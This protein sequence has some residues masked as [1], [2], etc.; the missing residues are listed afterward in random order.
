MRP[1]SVGDYK[2][3]IAALAFS[4]GGDQAASG[5]WD[6]SARAWDAK[7]G[8]LLRQFVGNQAVVRGVAFA[9]GGRQLV[10]TSWDGTARLWDAATGSERFKYQGRPLRGSRDAGDTGGAEGQG[11]QGRGRRPERPLPPYPGLGRAS[12]APVLL[13]VACPSLTRASVLPPG[14]FP[15]AAFAEDGCLACGGGE[16]ANP[17]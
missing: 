17:S 12:I 1:I 4:P 11:C 13:D 7:T 14:I 8:R 16:Q 3:P 5:S 9:A 6:K 10:T 15:R 2:E